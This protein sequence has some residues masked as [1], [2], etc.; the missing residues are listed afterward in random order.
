LV[1]KGVNTRLTA[2][3]ARAL[4]RTFDAGLF[5]AGLPIGTATVTA[6]TGP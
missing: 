4:N 1:L 6:T 3:A 2:T 5:E